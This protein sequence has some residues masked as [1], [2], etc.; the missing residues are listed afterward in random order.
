M[1]SNSRRDFV[2]LAAAKREFH[3]AKKNGAASRRTRER[4][5]VAAAGVACENGGV[6]KTE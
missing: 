1:V 5:E 4:R 2:K 3:A 6:N